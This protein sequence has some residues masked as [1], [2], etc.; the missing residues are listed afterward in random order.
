MSLH[1]EKNILFRCL[2]S[3]DDGKHEAVSMSVQPDVTLTSKN[4]KKKKYKKSHGFV[5]TSL[6]P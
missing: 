2:L 4:K 1:K 6:R 5:L 3:L